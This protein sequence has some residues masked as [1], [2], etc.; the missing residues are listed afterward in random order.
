MASRREARA[1]L[2]PQDR[3]GP[4]SVK[5]AAEGEGNDAEAAVKAAA[6]AARGFAGALCDGKC[7]DGTSA[8]CG[9]TEAESVLASPPSRIPDS[10]PV[11]YKAEVT[12]SGKCECQV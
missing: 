10:N 1:D 8:N 3:C 9:Y 6:K 5:A 2:K 11:R 4:P 12:S 7:R